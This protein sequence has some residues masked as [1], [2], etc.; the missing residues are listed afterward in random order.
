M[1]SRFCPSP[2]GLMHLGNARTALF[3]ALLAEHTKGVFLLRIEDTDKVRSDEAYTHA[4]ME[5][6][7]WLELHWHEGPE[8]GGEH[9]P[10][11]QSQRQA[12]YDY[13]Y[14][15][16]M[17]AN[18]AYQCFC[19]EAQLALNR[20]VQQ[21]SGKPPRYPGTCRHL[22]AEDIAA[23]KAK[24]LQP[25]LRFKVSAAKKIIFNDLVRGQQIFNS[26]DIGDFIIRRAE[27]T[28][29]FLFCNAID[30][31]LM[32]VT[33]ALRGEDHLA[34]SPRQILLLE[35]LNL[36]APQY[37]HISMIL[38]ADGTLLSKRNGSR[39]VQ[40][41]KNQGYLP[42][43]IVNYL[44]RLGHYYEQDNLM[45]LQELAKN[46]LVERLVRAPAKFDLDQLNRWQKEV[47]MQL[48]LKAVWQWLAPTIELMIP[49]DQIDS[50][51]ET[52]RPNILFPSDAK[53]WAYAIF[54]PQLE[55]DVD[56]LQ[57]LREAGKAFFEVAIQAVDK[58]DTQFDKIASYVV[59]QTGFKGK[60]LFMPLRVALTGQPHGPDMSSLLQLM[61]KQSIQQRLLAALQQI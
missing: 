61:G 54:S 59:E 7:H 15:V 47:V 11:W 14:D 2:T 32:G 27:G 6:L 53:M 42:L 40:E 17:K 43:A 45:S 50:F 41:L 8:V 18:L 9:G 31:A 22:T 26:S 55:F 48:D 10:Y 1:K 12:I 19:S 37:A 25:T 28:A 57:I 44:A 58:F 46:F 38:G 23:K 49:S 29:S 52:I 16:L 35:A 60:K 56:H 3:N 51:V 20:K 30:D 33:H 36:K 34:N 13:Y 39:S 24:G 21:S 5:D 4:L